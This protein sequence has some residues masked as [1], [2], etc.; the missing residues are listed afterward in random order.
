MSVNKN[1]GVS[2]RARLLA[3]AKKENVQFEYLLLR[4]ALERFLYRLGVSSYANQFI[5]KGASVFTVWLGPFCRVTRDADVEALCDATPER[6]IEIFKAICQITDDDDAVE[7]DF[8]SFAHSVIKKEDKYPGTR[9]RFNAYVG[10][11]RVSLQF[12]IGV[13]DSVYPTAETMTYPTLLP[14]NAPHVKTYPRYTIVAEKLSTMLIRGMLNS[15]LKDYYDLW[16]LSESFAFEG[17][18]LE[19]AIRRTFQRRNVELPAAFPEALTNA[20]SDLPDKQNQWNAF[21][22]TLGKAPRPTSFEEAIARIQ[23]FLLPITWETRFH[24]CVWNPTIKKWQ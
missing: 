10:G 4:Y 19:E 13:G 6:L 1:K 8:D 20:F 5:L 21:I 17:V 11:A 16:L 22:R 18:L 9:I 15:R 7:F 23:C 2:I 24:N 12:D 14:L 3:V